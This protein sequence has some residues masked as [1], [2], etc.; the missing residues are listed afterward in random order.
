MSRK[1]LNIL[2]QGEGSIGEETIEDSKKE[3]VI[4]KTNYYLKRGGRKK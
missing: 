1:I 2:E 4:S 3:D